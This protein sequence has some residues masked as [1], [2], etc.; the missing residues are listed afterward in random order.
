MAILPKDIYR[1]SAIPIKIP[2]QF[3][4][5]IERAILKIIWNGKKPRITKTILSNKRTAGGITIF[6]FF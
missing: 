3:F 2:T 5:D 4:K 1:F 6:T